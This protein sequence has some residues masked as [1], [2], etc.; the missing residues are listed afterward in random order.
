[1][2]HMRNLSYEDL[3]RQLT[4]TKT[5][6]I[7]DRIVSAQ[8]LK[9]QVFA[10]KYAHLHT[11]LL[12]HC[13]ALNMTL[14]GRSLRY[15][16]SLEEL[17]YSPYKKQIAYAAPQGDHLILLNA[18]NLR[19]L[20]YS[21]P[22]SG[23][24]NLQLGV[25]MFRQH[26]TG[27]RLQVANGLRYENCCLLKALL[28]AMEKHQTLALVELPYN[29]ILRITFGRE[30]IKHFIALFGRFEVTLFSIVVGTERFKTI[31]PE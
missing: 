27:G 25:S 14:F 29:P 5:L 28:A 16:S 1:M 10:P 17:M 9:R 18:F 11:L 24:T 23:I 15:H 12:D 31:E 13:C 26:R 8:D 30:V 4:T 21:G 19:K 7:K 2:S 3:L 22:T 20:R 6:A